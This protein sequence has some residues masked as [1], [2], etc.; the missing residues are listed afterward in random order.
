[1]KQEELVPD[2][3]TCKRLKELGWD[4]ETCFQHWKSKSDCGVDLWRCPCRFHDHAPAPTAQELLAELPEYLL[5]ED[6]TSWP[7]IQKGRVFYI[8]SINDEC[9]INYKNY[10]NLAQ[11]LGEL[12]IW[13][14]ENYKENN[15]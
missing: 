4:K 2:F 6:K 12:F 11:A 8:V 7:Q 14:K 1:M 13:W 9:H 15:E 5:P 3:K 10:K